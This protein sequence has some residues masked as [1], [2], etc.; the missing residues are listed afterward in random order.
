MT[1][2]KLTCPF[3][4]KFTW[5]YLKLYLCVAEVHQSVLICLDTAVLC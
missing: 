2:F 4:Y 3:N 5:L 1:V